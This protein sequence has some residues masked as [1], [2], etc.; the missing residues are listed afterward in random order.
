MAEME[1]ILLRAG[2]N[3]TPVRLLVL[4]C[5]MA[6]RFPLSLSDIEMQ[7]ESVDKSTISRTLSSFRKHHLLHSFNDGSGS[8][9]YEYCAA[10]NHEE[11]DDT[12]VHFRCEKCGNTICFHSVAIPSVKIPEGFKINDISYL[13]TGI[14]NHCQRIGK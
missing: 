10:L 3:P 7:L 6:A 5:L 2:I 4:K 9:K 12:H 14:C 8:M 1:E 11:E 13:I